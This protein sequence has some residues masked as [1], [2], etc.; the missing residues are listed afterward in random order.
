MKKTPIPDAPPDNLEGE[1]VLEAE[2]EEMDTTEALSSK[3]SKPGNM[4]PPMSSL[5]MQPNADDFP[6]LIPPTV[7]GVAEEQLEDDQ[8]KKSARRTKTSHF[9]LVKDLLCRT[10]LPQLSAGSS[11]HT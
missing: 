11:D 3:R 10:N 7:K 2:S 8:E 6:P 5:V 4:P 9:I 1:I